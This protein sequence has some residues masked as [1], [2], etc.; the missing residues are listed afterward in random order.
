[1]NVPYQYFLTRV[2]FDDSLLTTPQ[3][4][5]GYIAKYKHENEMFDLKERD[6]ID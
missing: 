5:K 2:N 1:M 3:T 6:D 4:L